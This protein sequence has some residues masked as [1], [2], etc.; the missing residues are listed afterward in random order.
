MLDV[1]V[2]F[3]EKDAT[4]LYEHGKVT[5]D[6]ILARYY[7]TPFD[8]RPAGPVVTVAHNKHVTLR[9]WTQRPQTHQPTSKPDERD[10]K[11]SGVADDASASPQ[12]QLFVELVPAKAHRIAAPAQ[13]S[14]S[15]PPASGLAVHEEFQKVPL[16]NKR[17]D[18]EAGRVG[19]QRVTNRFVARLTEVDALKAGE[20]T[21]PVGFQLATVDAGE[22]RHDVEGRLEV[23]LRTPQQKSTTRPADT[24][25]ALIG[26]TLQ[27]RLGHLCEQKGCV[28]H[29]H[30]SLR[31]LAGLGGVRPHSNLQDPRATVYLR[32]G[33]AVD[34]WGRRETLRDRG[35]EIVGLV[36]RELGAYRLRVQ[37]PSWRASDKS[38]EVQQCLVCRERTAGVVEDLA[39]ADNI[40]VA[41][42]GINFRPAALDVD[43]VE[44]LDAIEQSGSAP[45]AVWLAPAGAAMPKPSPPQLPKRSDVPRQGGPSSSAVGIIPG[46]RHQAGRRAEPARGRIGGIGL[47]AVLRRPQHPRYR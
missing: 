28:A 14:L 12:I 41:G 42:G 34:V 30:K 18:D 7:D 46:R 44:L 31:D 36:P 3:K 47:V 26:G 1:T 39:W 5:L 9:G 2:R 33:R 6:Q 45:S 32:A 17:S 29:F 15:N 21:L 10:K 27:L 40:K 24:G 19:D 25:V 23:V 43:V 38:G 8:V 16:A 20:I 35:V 22:M 4:V 37:L 13:L 11:V